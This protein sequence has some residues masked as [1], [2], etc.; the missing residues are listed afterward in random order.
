MTWRQFALEPFAGL[1]FVD[2]HTDDFAET[3]GAASLV[4]SSGNSDTTFSS[5][6]IRSAAPIPGMGGLTARGSVA[7]RHAFGTVTPTTQLV[8][9]SG[10]TSFV[11]AGVPI[12][13]DAAAVEIGLDGPV[14]RE[15]T[16]GVAYTG[17]LAERAQDHAIKVNFVQRF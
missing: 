7:W 4:G 2:V 11:V 1:A 13:K 14:A 15:A 6:G 3:G 17:Q 9:A 8:F 5:L 10:G 12:A 16:L